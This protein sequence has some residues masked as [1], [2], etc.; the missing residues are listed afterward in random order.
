MLRSHFSRNH[1]IESALA[2]YCCWA[3]SSERVV[4]N[5]RFVRPVWGQGYTLAALQSEKVVLA[6]SITQL[7]SR[8]GQLQFFA[9][10]FF[11]LISRNFFAFFHCF[12]F[13]NFLQNI[14]LFR[15]FCTFFHNS[16]I[17]KNFFSK[18][19]LIKKNFFLHYFYF[20]KK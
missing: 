16:L 2:N 6:P 1:S 7:C 10:S 14:C 12:F 5:H 19:F 8:E 18:F 9:Q 17:K 11:F 4:Y 13:R 3:R 20:S 15:N